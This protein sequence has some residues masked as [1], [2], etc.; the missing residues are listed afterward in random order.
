[1]YKLNVCLKPSG[2]PLKRTEARH[3]AG[4]FGLK[5]LWAGSYVL[6]RTTL[7]VVLALKGLWAGGYV[8]K[9]DASSD[10]RP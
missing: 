3:A 5:G 9:R 1:V 8:L 10:R 2:P 7:L 6:K 4:G